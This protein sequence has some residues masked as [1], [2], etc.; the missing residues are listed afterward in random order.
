MLLPGQRASAAEES[1]GTLP[2]PC[3]PIMLHVSHA[4]PGTSIVYHATLFLRNLRQYSPSYNTSPSNI[5]QRQCYYAL[6]TQC[7]VLTLPMLL[8][9]ILSGS[10]LAPCVGTPCPGTPRRPGTPPYEAGS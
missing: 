9:A 8:P 6:P 7:P 4:L 1:G 2:R 5:R 10:G 3:P